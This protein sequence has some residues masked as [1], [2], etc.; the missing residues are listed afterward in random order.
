MLG[1][2]S[3]P[4]SGDADF[5]FQLQHNPLSGFFSDAFNFRQQ[6]HG[7]ID[8]RIFKIRHGHPAEHGE[9][10]LRTY[11]GDIVD[12]QAEKVAL[13]RAHET[14][15]HMCVLTHLEMREQLDRRAGRRQFVK[16]R[17]RDLRLIANAVHRDHDVCRQ[18]LSQCAL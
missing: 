10:E 5:I 12:E 17:Q 15:K 16:T 4:C 7:L 9:R 8:H 2:G 11:A 6:I 1:A 18:R 13:L 14:E 3:F